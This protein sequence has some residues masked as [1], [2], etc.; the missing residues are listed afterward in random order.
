[1]LEGRRIAVVVPARDE[2]HWISGVI[3]SM[4]ELVDDIIV[5]DDGSSD[6]TGEIAKRLGAVVLT[7]A[8]ARGVGAAIS[9][10]YEHALRLGADVVAVM[11]GD[12]QMCPDDLPRLLA[13]VLDGAADYVKGDRFSH[14]DVAHV[15]PRA[16][17]VVGGALSA[18][19]AL[20]TGIDGLSDSQ[21]GYTVASRRALSSVDLSALWPRY[22]YPNDL[23]SLLA[24]AGMRVRQVT[25]RPVYRGEASGL[26]FW[27][28]ATI[29]ALIGRAALRRLRPSWLRAPSRRGAQAPPTET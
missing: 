21:C 13:P 28:V 10:G 19:T 5:V 29:G 16:R 25:V 2:A 3:S 18:A 26:R 4:P 27:H 20:A 8:P 14:P 6:G 17:R 24:Q 12:G 1:V 11:A 7:R 22:G 23:L 15:M 9:A